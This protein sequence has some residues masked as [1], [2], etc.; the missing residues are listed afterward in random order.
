MMHHVIY[1]ATAATTN[2]GAT[3]AGQAISSLMGS[4][5][6]WISGLGITGG[7]LM[8]AYHALM[9]NLSGGDGATDAHHL[10]AM[11]KVIVG[12]A[13]VAGAGGI[14]HFAGGLF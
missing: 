6:T 5:G 4:A 8:I 12:T 3:K 13:I 7:G 1:L 9:R 11:K 2:V 14:A 10:Q